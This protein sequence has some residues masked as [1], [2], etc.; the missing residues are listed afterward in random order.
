MNDDVIEAF[1]QDP[2]APVETRLLSPPSR[3]L[4][5]LDPAHRKAMLAR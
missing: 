3:I 1:E 5:D 4:E 2:Q